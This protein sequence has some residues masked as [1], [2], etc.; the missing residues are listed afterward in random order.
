MEDLRFRYRKVWIDDGKKRKGNL[1]P[2]HEVRVIDTE[3]IEQIIAWYLDNGGEVLEIEE[4]SL[5]YGQ[6]LCT[7]VENTQSMLITEHYQNE[8][9]SYHTF[10]CMNRMPKKYTEKVRT[11]YET[12]YAR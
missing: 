10:R 8:W 4:G 2:G 6:I 9:S 1:F 5:G 12:L 11:Y 7:G 3:T